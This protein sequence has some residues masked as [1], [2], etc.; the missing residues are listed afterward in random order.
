MYRFFLLMIFSLCVLSCEKEEADPRVGSIAGIVVDELAE[1]ESPCQIKLM[2]GNEE[3]ET[4]TTEARGRF[5]FLNVPVGRYEILAKN[6]QGHKNSLSIEVLK[7]K[8]TTITLALGLAT[9]YVKGKVLNA[10]SEV[11]A[12]AQVRILRNG[13]LVSEVKT[14]EFGY[15]LMENIQPEEYIIEFTCPGY[16]MFSKSFIKKEQDSHFVVSME[17]N[18]RNIV[19]LVIDRFGKELSDVTVKLKLNNQDKGQRLTNK[20]GNFYFDEV[21]ERSYKLEVSRGGYKTKSLDLVV[22]Y[23]DDIIR[24]VMTPLS[25]PSGGFIGY[26]NSVGEVSL[27]LYV[28]DSDGKFMPGFIPDNFTLNPVIINGVNVTF[29]VSKVEQMNTPYIGTTSSGILLDQSGSI[30]TEDPDDLR[31]HGTKAFLSSLKKTDEYLLGSFPAFET[32]SENFLTNP[33]EVYPILDQLANNEGGSTPLYSSSN[34]MLDLINQKSN[35]ANKNLIIFTD[36]EGHDDELI[37]T[38]I[39]KAKSDGIRI[40]SI[41]LGAGVN[42]DNLGR[43]AFET[44]GIYLRAEKADNLISIFSSLYGY[45]AG[46]ASYYRTT[47]KVSASSNVSNQKVNSSV[48]VDVNGESINIPVGFMLK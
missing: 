18:I 17:Y 10:E 35:N 8:I 2:K 43:L 48:L 47:W 22:P 24:I 25:N 21:E 39:Q 46:G 44:G 16:K 13:I 28:V 12:N 7:S 5:R 27:D 9:D 34:S 11:L 42:N 37:G 36:G 38:V 30:T 32:H 41:G 6:S 3:I 20:I 1:E 40:F 15:F 26:Q 29:T 23:S 45:I 14:N 31:I 4:V 19:G 33:K